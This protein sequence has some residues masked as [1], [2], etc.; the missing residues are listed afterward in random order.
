M[1]VAFFPVL[2]REIEGLDISFDGKMLARLIDKEVE[3]R[4]VLLGFEPLM[5][6]FGPDPEMLEEFDLE[7]D[8][9][10]TEKW[11]AADAG[12]KSVTGLRRDLEANPGE[13]SLTERERPGAV[14]DLKRLGEILAEAAR[15]GGRWYLAID[16]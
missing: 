16:F 6:F 14:E 2:E 10:M 1:G 12:L 3:K 4:A 11:F 5:N 13:Y 15:H 7:A 9:E 8:T